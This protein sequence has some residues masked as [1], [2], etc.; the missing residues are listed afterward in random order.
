MTPTAPIPDALFIPE[1]LKRGRTLRERIDSVL[2]LAEPILGVDRAK[3]ERAWIRRQ[4][5]GMLFV[6]RDPNDTIC[7][8]DASPFRGRHRYAWVAGADGIRRG[9][10]TTEAL[11]DRREEPAEAGV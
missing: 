1:S 6:S 10:L 2:D 11:R 5:G 4:P 9:W 3:G 8:P 7:H